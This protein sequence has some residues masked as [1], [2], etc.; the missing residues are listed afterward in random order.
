MAFALAYT[1]SVS[2]KCE[3]NKV[4]SIEKKLVD[5]KKIER[6]GEQTFESKNRIDKDVV[7]KIGETKRTNPE[8]DGTIELGN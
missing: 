1:I 4:I 8:D 6:P 2:V 7:V 5:P 3:L